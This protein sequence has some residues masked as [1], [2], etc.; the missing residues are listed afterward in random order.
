MENEKIY[1]SDMKMFFKSLKKSNN[2]YRVFMKV[3]EVIV[4][5]F[6]VLN[7]ALLLKDVRYIN[8][9][10]SFNMA[11]FHMRP[12]LY[13]GTFKS[14]SMS[15]KVQCIYSLIKYAP[16]DEKEFRKE[17]IRR[18]VMFL[19]KVLAAGAVIQ[20]I[21]FLAVPNQYSIWNFVSMISFLFIFPLL[22]GVIYIIW[23][24]KTSLY[25]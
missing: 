22:A 5:V 20:L 8:I 2:E 16:F 24:E 12:Y 10:F 6:T 21:E 15:A 18:L 3:M 1:E 7:S 23:T 4:T 13:A 9:I 17:N 25:D 11:V 14:D 19:L